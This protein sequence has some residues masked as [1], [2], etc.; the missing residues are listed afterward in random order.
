MVKI[1]HQEVVAVQGVPFLDRIRLFKGDALDFVEIFVEDHPLAG[2][3][4]AQAI[5]V[6]GTGLIVIAVVGLAVYY[7]LFKIPQACVHSF[8]RLFFMF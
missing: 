5:V 3:K 4:A 7:M 6:L 8:F 2:C 1:Q